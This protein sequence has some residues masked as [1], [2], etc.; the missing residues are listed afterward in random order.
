VSSGSDPTRISSFEGSTTLR[1][2]PIS[3]RSCEIAAIA[4][5]AAALASMGDSYSDCGNITVVVDP[6][7]A[8]KSKGAKGL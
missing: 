2:S 8:A 7:K 3:A 5:G 1:S 6:R 4:T